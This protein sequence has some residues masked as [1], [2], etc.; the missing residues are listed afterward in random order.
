MVDPFFTAA[1]LHFDHMF[2]RYGTPVVVINLVKARERTPRETLLLKEFT[3]AILYLNQFLPKEHQLRYV[4][5]D[6]SR[7]S[8]SRDQE[9]IGTLEKIAQDA[10]KETKF[11][12]SGTKGL[13]LQSGVSRTNCIDCLDRTNAA[14]FVIGKHAMSMQ[15][16]A[17]GLVADP[18]DVKY[19]CDA[20]SMMIEMYH[21]HGDTV[22]L[23]YGGSH[24]VNTME[25]YRKINQWHSHSRDMI[26]SIRRFYHNS[27]LDAQ[28]QEAINL[29]LGN[30]KVES[31]PESQNLWEMENDYRLHYNNAVHLTGHRDYRR[32]W[33]P[34]HLEHKTPCTTL[35]TGG[36]G[37]A[38]GVTARSEDD[39]GRYWQEYYRLNLHSHL[40]RHFCF[41]M[42]DTVNYHPSKSNHED[43]DPSPFVVRA[44]GA[45]STTAIIKSPR[46]K[47]E[48][49]TKLSNEKGHRSKLS[50][51]RWLG[52]ASYERASSLDTPSDV[53]QRR[54]RHYSSPS[55]SSS[56]TN[57][58]VAA[59]PDRCT[60]DA[61][62]EDEDADEQEHDDRMIPST[63]GPGETL[64][65]SSLEPT[66]D[67]SKHHH[68]HPRHD[69]TVSNLR[70]EEKGGDGNGKEEGNE[71]EN[72]N[73]DGDEELAS[74][75]ASLLANDVA[76]ERMRVYAEYSDLNLLSLRTVPGTTTVSGH[77]EGDG[78]DDE[79]MARY[80]G[81][82][83]QRHHHHQQHRRHHHH[84]QSLSVS[85][86]DM[87]L[88]RSTCQV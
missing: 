48:A 55:S 20:V 53:R 79:I 41:H 19:D 10:M 28:R 18:S 33:T 69:H 17:L 38:T 60:I 21:D 24:L 30:F 6:M 9:V 39:N 64:M 71:N 13:Q 54:R 73:G 23:Q 31:A 85:P 12:H 43:F 47:V 82:D 76:G 77:G 3:E 15:L 80:A 11:F 83:R 8:K 4:A 52:H 44:H 58:P 29:F 87:A 35:T 2:A 22:A 46:H 34:E 32:W 88:Y 59:V 75:V 45:A 42:N 66:G 70:V 56:G 36:Q 5:W 25:T 26:E 67:L 27:F 16:Y 57:F 14:Q 68:H 1:A 61:I 40:K 86:A 49:E 37:L 72:E 51:H 62:D 84:R 63:R 65:H 78:N 74:L 81:P 50:L 7:A